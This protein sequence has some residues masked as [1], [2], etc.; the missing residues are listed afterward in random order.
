MLDSAKEVALIKPIA[1][2]DGVHPINSTPSDPWIFMALSG[3]H[4]TLPSACFKPSKVTLANIMH[5]WP[6]VVPSRACDFKVKI[7][8]SACLF[9]KVFSKSKQPN[10]L[11]DVLATSLSRVWSSSKLIRKLQLSASWTNSPRGVHPKE[12]IVMFVREVAIA[13]SSV[14]K[15]SGTVLICGGG[16]ARENCGSE[17]SALCAPTALAAPVSSLF[18]KDFGTTSSSMVNCGK[19]AFAGSGNEVFPGGGSN[20][21]GKVGLGEL[22][23]W[24]FFCNGKHIVFVVSSMY[25]PSILK[26]A[27]IRAFSNSSAAVSD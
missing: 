3:A 26:A 21:A 18:L 9:R 8:P 22:L 5:A 1:I 20:R 12:D 24:P 25:A 4:K 15:P 23:T 14:G 16:P 2:A 17:C 11:L 6:N 13:V 19:E 27:F 7:W 10:G